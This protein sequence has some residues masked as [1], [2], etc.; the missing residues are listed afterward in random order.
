MSD[1]D[2]TR[3]EVRA[4][5]EASLREAELADQRAELGTATVRR[6][7]ERQARWLGLGA[8]ALSLVFSVATAVWTWQNSSQLA[9]AEVLRVQSEQETDAALDSLSAANRALSARGQ[10]PVPTPNPDDPADTIAAAVTARVLTQL[11][12]TPTAQQVA[13]VLGPTSLAMPPV[14]GPTQSDLAARVA[15]YFRANESALQGPKG[16]DGE[17]GPRGPGPTAE[18]IQAAVNAAYAANPPPPGRDGQNGTNGRDG[19]PGVSF[20]GLQFRRDD[21]GMCVAVVSFSDGAEQTQPVPDV[22]CG[23]DVDTPEPTTD[24][25]PTTN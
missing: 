1:A 3:D 6:V 18:Q 20:T 17:E 5:Q 23:S 8:V 4:A 13:A 14:T 10:P 16:D 12:P 22:V 11:P 2:P 7:V 19:D 25:P 24:P 15:D 9:A 21:M